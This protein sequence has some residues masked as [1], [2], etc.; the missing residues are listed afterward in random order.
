[1]LQSV[2]HVSCCERRTCVGITILQMQESFSQIPQQIHNR[3]LA[4]A[5][6]VSYNPI[7]YKINPQLQYIMVPT[8]AATTLNVGM[9]PTNG[10]SSS[11]K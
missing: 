6:D 11:N 7:N 4:N 9:I 2:G 3:A 5:R 8:N 10:Y 1:M